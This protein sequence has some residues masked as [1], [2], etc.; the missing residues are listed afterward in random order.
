M[1]LGQ[2][3]TE[4]S[5]ISQVYA[6]RLHWQSAIALN[7]KLILTMQAVSLI[8]SYMQVPLRYPLRL[9]CSRSYIRDY[10]PS[11]EHSTSDTTVD[12]MLST[13]TKLVEFPLFVDGQDSTR[14]AYAVFL[15]NKVCT[16]SG[17]LCASYDNGR[18]SRYLVH[19]FLPY[20]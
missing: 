14:A 9:G 1:W 11:I 10:A 16:F 13:S 6:S 15:L 4:S 2:C 7:T 5:I 17:L 18:S 12:S 20:N 8:A 3:Q 19:H